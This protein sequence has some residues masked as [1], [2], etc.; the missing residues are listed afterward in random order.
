MSDTAGH[1]AWQDGYAAISVSR[2]QANAVRAYIHDQ[3]RHH[4]KRSYEQELMV[5]LDRSGVPYDREYLL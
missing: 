3:E 1:F 2:S 4:A 5:L